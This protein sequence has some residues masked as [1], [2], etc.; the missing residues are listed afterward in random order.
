MERGDASGNWR[1]PPAMAAAG[2]L[3]GVLGWL[4]IGMLVPVLAQN[5]GHAPKPIAPAV[6]PT[7]TLGADTPGPTIVSPTPLPLGGRGP[8]PAIP[9]PVV[10]D[11]NA[12]LP[13]DPNTE[14]PTVPPPTITGNPV[15]GDRVPAPVITGLAPTPPPALPPTVIL[16]ADERTG[17]GLGPR[18]SLG[19]TGDPHAFSRAGLPERNWIDQTQAQ[20]D[21]KSAGCLE[22]HHGVEPMHKSPY[23]VLGCTDCH[24]GDPTKGKKDTIV[25]GVIPG[26][27]RPTYPEF[28][29]TAANPANSSTL[30]NHENPDWIRFV[31]PGD[32]R[33]AEQACGLCHPNSLRHVANSMMT[34]GQMLWGAALYN[35]GSYWK[36]NYVFAQAYGLD[37]APLKITNPTPVTAAMTQQRGILPFLLPLPRF[38]LSMPGNTLR[39]FEK[40]GVNPPELANPESTARNG[41]PERATSARGEG[42]LLRTDPVF[43]G[44]QKTRLNDPLLPFLGS[45]DHPGDYRSSG[46][47]G[48]HT[49][50]ANDRSPTNSGWYSKYGHQGLSF[51]ADPTINK[52]ERGHPVSHQFTRSIPSSQC[53]SCHMHQGNLFVNPYLGYTWWDQESD[54]ELMYPKA[55]HDPTDAE[56]L[57]S[58]RKNPEAAAAR[59]LWGKEEFLEKVAELNPKLKN[60]QFA[61][62]HSHGWVFRAVFKKDRKGNLLDL[63]D[64]HIAADDPKK[65]QKAVH[66]NDIHLQKGMQCVDCHFLRD[67]H[68]D[69]TLYAEP[70]AATSIECIDCHGTVDKRPTLVTSGNGGSVDL[71]DGGTP[72]GP[73]FVW[74]DVT[75]P[76]TTQVNG[77]PVQQYATRRAL[78]QNSSMEAGKRWEVPQTVD[79][80][81]PASPRYNAKSA[82]AKTLHRDGTAWGDVP[83]DPDVR[84][85]RLAHSNEKITC[86]VCHSSWAT[87]CFGC[88]LPMKANQKVPLNKFE[89]TTDR[90]YTTYNPQVVRDDVFMLGIDGTV[91]KNRMAVLRSSSA[92][93][94]GS[95]N[96][97][98]EWVYSQQQTVSAEGYSGQAFNPHFPHTTSGAGTT[99]GCTDCH[100]SKGGDNNAW[101]AQLL[102]FGTGTVNFF[103]RYA[104]VGAG[105]EGI[106]AAVWTEQDEPQAAIGSHLHK[107]A[108]PKN[109]A[110]HAAG[111]SV[112][113]SIY[114]HHATDCRDLTQRGEFL[115]TANGRGGFRVYDIANIDNKAFS[116]RFNTS[117]VSPLGENM[118]VQ[119]R[120]VATSLALPSTLAL[121]PLRQHLPENEETPIPSYYGFIYGTDTVEGLVEIGVGTLVDGNPAN[122]FLHKDL[123]FNPDGLLNGATYVAA[124]GSRLYITSPQGLSV[125]SV[126]DPLHPTL[127]SQAGGGFLRNPRAVAVQFQYAFVTDEDG[128]KIF[129]LADPDR[130]AP[131]AGAT[132]PLADAN[133]LYVARTYA[134]VANGREGLAIID[135]ERP[136]HPKL[137]QMYNAD[138]QL[139]DVRAVQVGSVSASMFALVAD[140]RNGL[141]VVQLISPENVPEH[142]GFSPKPNPVLIATAP[143]KGGEAIAVGRGLDRDRVVDETGAQTVVFGR[144][145][146]RPFTLAEMSS[147]LR[148]SG[149]G[150]DGDDA[151]GA[152][153]AGPFYRV[154]DAVLRKD[155]VTGAPSL[156]TRSG[157]TL[158][159]TQP[160][161]DPTATPGPSPAP[162]TAPIDRIFP[163]VPPVPRNEFMQPADVERLLKTNDPYRQL[164][165]PASP[166]T[167]SPTA[168]PLHDS[169]APAAQAPSDNFFALPGT[170]ERLLRARTPAG[171]TPAST[172]LPTSPP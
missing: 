172:P 5:G 117:P 105:K 52:R 99:K 22:C 113:R 63:D 48:C 102:G 109:Y 88:H 129:N 58:V 80:V 30:L 127:K 72:F 151:K 162:G 116:E 111:G 164:D 13:T 4:L 57:A 112:L 36:K 147:F 126:A 46:C 87:S 123:T 132:L 118:H 41:A 171:A 149:D 55:Q 67:A 47:T 69:G 6:P 74:E 60:T 97:N 70:R 68:G 152:V 139:N 2:L 65:W 100:L 161:Q 82:Y 101:M 44:L 143:L 89:G 73:R 40:G 110:D 38:N 37:G 62:Y 75:E 66:L 96:V 159:A 153:R 64:Q 17:N 16:S 163:V 28:W 31:N 146:S 42:T 170:A 32:L 165:R 158:R 56:L 51:S 131:V 8:G 27:V 85:V 160:F 140:G 154:E 120:G 39:I 98:R 124:A 18:T 11:T 59:G 119:T 20:A 137:V 54:G 103:G 86:Q 53:M 134:Y 107:L 168:P 3:L 108:Y 21:V 15:R 106:R 95:Q 50:Y 155:G 61:D 128:L 141:R 167:L 71:A 138:G 9:P 142:M 144:R 130:P 25:E 33:V 114:E 77:Q 135:V 157:E 1:K 7:V 94:V 166:S 24:G 10:L 136:E 29:R 35:N 79:T 78:Y 34:T 92:V 12:P 122:N 169:P 121:D 148:H 19:A 26:H 104:W 84:R 45:N 23:V 150:A 43:L 14:T 115:Y 81:N 125:V 156:L 83:A 93:V 76:A 90:N 145:G 49:V 91:K 133:R